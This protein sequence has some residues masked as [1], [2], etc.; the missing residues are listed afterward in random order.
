MPVPRS[1]IAAVTIKNF[2]FFQQ[3]QKIEINESNLLLYGENGSGKSSIYWALYTLLECANKED[4]EE[5]KKYFDPTKDERLTNI[6]LDPGT[7]NWVDSEIKIDLQDGTSFS[8]SLADTSINTNADAQSANYSSEFLN[9]KM[10]FQLHNFAHSDYID[11]F[12]YFEREVLP[13][14]KFAPVK[15]WLKKA[16]GTPDL[17][18]ETEN[19]KQIWDFVKNGPPKSGLMKDGLRPRYPY[20]R[21]PEFVVYKN[22]IAAFKSELEQLLTFIN[23][24]GNPILKTDFGYNFSFKLELVDWVPLKLS[25]LQFNYPR[26]QI[27]LDIPDF[28]TKLGVL[29]RILF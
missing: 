9:Y 5:I 1:N 21:E 18:Q 16:D 12:Q 27:K 14:V 4:T 22:I 7:A 26:F 10:I 19:A 3:E 11:I 28:Y 24:Q 17:E 23:T 29:R 25:A 8:V 2:K 13:Y 15:Y 20:R 6:F